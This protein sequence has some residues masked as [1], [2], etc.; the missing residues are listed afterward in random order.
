MTKTLMALEIRRTAF[1]PL[2]WLMAGLL[3][4]IAGWLFIDALERFLQLQLL[5][6]TPEQMPS[7]S[8][9]MMSRYL[10]P[11]ALI[12][13]L[14]SPLLCMRGIARGANDVSI[15]LLFTASMSNTQIALGKYF[16]LFFLQVA[17]LLP[18]LLMLLSLVWITDVDVWLFV[19]AS[20]M[21]VLFI[22]HC[23]GIGFLC[24]CTAVT[25]ITSAFMAMTVMLMLWLVGNSPTDMT[26]NLTMLAYISPSMHLVQGLQGII[27]SRDWLFFL[28][29]IGLMLLL[30]IERVQYLR[31]RGLQ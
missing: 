12:H 25:P 15:Q 19:V 30:S 14:V 11:L 31:G 23:V 29:T 16:A 2:F 3:Q 27:D 26:Q 18:A 10:A 6:Q 9:F 4:V 7:L 28:L 24:A 8:H 22:A 21:M 1:T 20:A 13:M 5:A 17:L